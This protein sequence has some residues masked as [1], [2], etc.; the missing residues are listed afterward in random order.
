MDTPLF[1]D[2]DRQLSAY[3]DCK[4]WIVAYSGGLD[5]HVLLHLVQR[6]WAEMPQ[7][8]SQWEKPRLLALHINHGLNPQADQWQEHCARNARLAGI[9]FLSESVVVQRASRDSLENAARRARYLAFEQ[10]LETDDLLLMAHHQDDQIE[11]FLLRQLRGS[12]IRGLTAM[13]A[14]RALGRAR[15]FRP[16]LLTTRQQILD[17]AHQHHLQWIED[18]SNLDPVYDR[19]YL[20]H[21]L[22]PKLADRWSGYRKTLS[23]VI[24]QIDESNQLL[25]DLASIDLEDSRDKPYAWG[26]SALPLKPL[27]V[28]TWQ[29]QKNALRYWLKKKNLP[30][31][32]AAQIR[33]LRPMLEGGASPLAELRFAG[34]C[35][36]CYNDQLIVMPP[37]SKHEKG[38]RYVIKKQELLTIEGVGQVQLLPAGLGQGVLLRDNLHIR[39]RK[40][41]ERCKPLGRGGTQSLKKLLQDR[42]IPPW[43]RDRVPLLYG[44]DQLLAVADLWVCDGCSPPAN[45]VGYQLQWLRPEMAMPGH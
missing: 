17:Y 18:E 16:L 33:E 1:S 42:R 22:I 31:P 12:G 19:N 44:G 9:E 27:R 14:K 32:T 5:S 34:I 37:L 25:D 43:W 3:A 2:I 8:N 35:L 29:R 40:G 24:E 7:V 23:R 36:R 4:R 6:A 11:T 10:L 39:F 21:L 15:L 38:K 41:G 26:G 45:Q 30:V 28:L 13:P 20:R